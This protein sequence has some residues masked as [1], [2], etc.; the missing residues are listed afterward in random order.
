MCETPIAAA[1]TFRKACICCAVVLDTVSA[2]WPG[3]TSIAGNNADAL[4]N[5]VYPSKLVLPFCDMTVANLKVISIERL[6]LLCPPRR[7]GCNIRCCKA[8]LH[9]CNC[10]FGDTN[11]WKGLALVVVPQSVAITQLKATLHLVC[12]GQ[13]YASDRMW[14]QSAP[15]RFTTRILMR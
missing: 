14:Q 12:P 10:G 7:P 13:C 2:Q 3:T 4:L 15:K 9:S 6:P 11:V 1:A 8:T 5:V